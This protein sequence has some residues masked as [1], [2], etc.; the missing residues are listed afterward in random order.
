MSVNNHSQS[1]K[2]YKVSI[3]V[4]L[5]NEEES[6]P[7][8]VKAIDDAL[9]SVEFEWELLLVNDG[10]SDRTLHVAIETQQAYG[11]HI[12]IIA[13]QRNFGQTAAMQA[14]IEQSIGDYIVTLDGDLQN[15]P[16]D[17]P[18]MVER[19]IE[20][21]LDLLVGWRKDRKDNMLIRKVPSKIAN[22]LIGK[23]TGVKLNDYGCSLKVYRGSIIRSVKL[24]GEMHRFIP[25]WVAIHVPVNRIE[26][27]EVN[28]HARQFGE[29]KYTI[30]RVYR[31]IL[32]LISVIYFMRFRTRP[33]HFFG[34][35]GLFCGA[36]GSLMMVV[37][38]FD[39]FILGEEIGGR[40]MLMIGIL[41][42]LMAMQFITTGILAE[43]VSRT[44][45]ESSKRST[46]EF[47]EVPYQ[48]L[49]SEET[50]AS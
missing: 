46:Y 17:I 26:E 11:A 48:A 43:V 33:S 49:E 31:V 18:Q 39:K 10:S 25:A 45:Y 47:V 23:A 3:V 5:Y 34:P 38:G 19:L 14:G 15:D 9:K 50:E 21:D 35:I 2:N 40:P 36:L 29:S 12:R 6:V 44:Y 42:I 41:L 22:W 4:P 24:Y 27:V 28:H 20:R 37:L 1:C 30:S 16:A 8:L 32:D 13:L 7:P